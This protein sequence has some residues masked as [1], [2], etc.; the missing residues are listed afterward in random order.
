MAATGEAV[1]EVIRR[2]GTGDLHL[3]LL[4]GCGGGSEF[5]V[6]ALDALAVDEMRDIEDHLAVFR[7]AAGDFFIERAEETAHLEADGTGAG[8]PLALASGILAQT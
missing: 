6:V 7:K 4:H 1:D 8:L 5:V 2:P 3:A